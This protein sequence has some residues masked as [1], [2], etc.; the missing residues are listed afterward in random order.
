M[1]FRFTG[2]ADEAG[3]PLKDQID[4]TKRAG[5]SS[6]EVR[7][8]DGT[9]VTD[10]ADGAFAAALDT[11]QSNGI[12]IA[13]FGAQLANWSRPITTDFQVDV[14]EMKRAIPRM[15]KCGAKIIRCMSYPHKDLERE[16]YKK[17]VFRRLKTLAKMAEDGGVILGHENCNGFG[18]EGPEQSLEMLAAVNSPAF[19]LIF[20]SG[21]NA[22]HDNDQNATWNFYNKVKEHIVHVHLK[23]AKP[24]PEGKLITCY[25]DE[26]PTQLKVLSDLKKRGYDGWLSIEPHMAAAIHAGK[27]VNDAKAAADIYVEYARR[28]VALVAKA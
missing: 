5:W 24:G 7:G 22:L 14:D 15:H 1:A 28:A 8:I 10:M 16:A 4:A 23:A 21:N 26:D 2:F 11:L 17:E 19:K 27:Q 13:G 3:K 9:F 12:Q 25:P 18:G 6:I 20:D